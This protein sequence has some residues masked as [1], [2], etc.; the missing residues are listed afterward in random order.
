MYF[1]SDHAH[2]QVTRWSVSGVVSFVGPT[3]ISWTSKR[4]GTIER[5][6]NSTEFC[7]GRV[8]SEEA[9]ALRY[10]L[11]SL[12]VPIIG[13]TELCGDNLGI[14]ISSTNPDSELNKKNVAISYHKLQEC[15]EAGIFN[16]IKVCTTVNRADIFTKSVLVGTLGSLPD[17]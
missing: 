7:A 17:A 2:D 3:P 12:G 9:I 8:A 4:Q 11:R 5:S 15:T 14:I 13:A 10:M 6:S 1:D 16:P